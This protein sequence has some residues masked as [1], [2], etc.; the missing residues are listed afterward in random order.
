MSRTR[1]SGRF[2]KCIYCPQRAHYEKR[3]CVDCLQVRI[4]ARQRKYGSQYVADIA[5]LAGGWT[6][7]GKN[8]RRIDRGE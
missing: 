1:H 3:E 4:D 7:R 5:K 8:A 2:R 6:R